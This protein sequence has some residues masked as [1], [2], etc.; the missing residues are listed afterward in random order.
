ML[1]GMVTFEEER[2]FISNLVLN[3][4]IQAVPVPASPLGEN[5]FGH[6]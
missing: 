4:A 5:N 1:Q 3:R 6:D 2:K